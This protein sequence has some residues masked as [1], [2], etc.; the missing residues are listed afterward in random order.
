MPQV[1]I[2]AAASGGLGRKRVAPK[3]AEGEDRPEPLFGEAVCRILFAAKMSPHIY[4]L[5]HFP[6]ARC[7]RTLPIRQEPGGGA[8][9][10]DRNCSAILQRIIAPP[11]ILALTSRARANGPTG[12][13]GKVRD[14]RARRY[15]IRRRRYIVSENACSKPRRPAGVIVSARLSRRRSIHFRSK[16]RLASAAPT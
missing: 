2:L 14:H 9:A 6:G 11:W 13:S 15:G 3:R 4:K 12:R 10:N 5:E 16:Q 1:C 7:S 8:S